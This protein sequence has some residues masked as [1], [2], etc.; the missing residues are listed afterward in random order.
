MTSATLPDSV[1]ELGASAFEGCSALAS[2]TI[3]N[4]VEKIGDAAFKNCAALTTVNYT[5]TEEQWGK[6]SKSGVGIPE[7]I[8]VNYSY[9]A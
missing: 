6:I 7:N 9:T 1:K 3:G 5:G 8:T 4:G 2:V